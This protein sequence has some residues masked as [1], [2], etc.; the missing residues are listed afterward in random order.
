MKTV[1][2]IPKNKPAADGKKNDTAKADNKPA[3]GGKNDKPT[4]SAK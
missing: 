3:E 1:G 4:D 2:Y